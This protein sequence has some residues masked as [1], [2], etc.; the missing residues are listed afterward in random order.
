[1]NA[2]AGGEGRRCAIVSPVPPYLTRYRPRPF[3]VSLEPQPSD[4]FR[5]DVRVIGL[6]GLAHASSHFFLLAEFDVSW[7]V[8]GILLG[9][10]YAASALTQFGAGFAV[11][12]LGARPVLLGGLT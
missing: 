1:M 7:T 11:D 2:A 4:S 10:F 8:L 3:Q 5:R 9:V 12:R 6:V